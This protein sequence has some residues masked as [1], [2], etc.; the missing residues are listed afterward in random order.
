MPQRGLIDFSFPYTDRYDPPKLL[1]AK[2]TSGF[3]FQKANITLRFAHKG[4]SK[5]TLQK[6]FGK[7]VQENCYIARSSQIRGT[8]ERTVVLYS[9]GTIIWSKV[10]VPYQGGKPGD[11]KD[12]PI[13]VQTAH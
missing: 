1:L 5:T 3:R 13:I 2:S 12:Q 10:A 6:E 9:V 11:R 7:T 4:S 8:F